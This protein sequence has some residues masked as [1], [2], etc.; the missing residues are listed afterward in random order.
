M[1]LFSRKGTRKE[2]EWFGYKGQ[3]IFDSVELRKWILRTYDLKVDEFIRLCILKEF[4]FR[5]MK[6]GSVQEDEEDWKID[7]EDI[8]TEDSKI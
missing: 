1:K 3:R 4:Y 6:W 5:E 7:M 2:N 8:R